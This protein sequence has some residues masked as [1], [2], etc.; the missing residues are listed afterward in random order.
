MGILNC[1]CCLDAGIS[2]LILSSVLSQPKL[3]KVGWISGDV[4][5]LC[6]K[7]TISELAYVNLL[8]WRT[9]MLL[10]AAIIDVGHNAGSLSSVKL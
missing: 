10:A 1:C 3:S 7:C 6:T 8:V 2:S 9:L 4:L 5:H